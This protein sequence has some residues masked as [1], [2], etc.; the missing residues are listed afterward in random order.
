MQ[1]VP[2]KCAHQTEGVAHGESDDD[3]RG[4]RFRV[5]GFDHINGI[6]HVGPENEIHQRLRPTK[7]NKRRPET[8]PATDQRANYQPNLIRTRHGS[9]SLLIA[10]W[11]GA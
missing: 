3:E 6:D 1:F 4:R 5:E 2:E 7:Q 8:V 11:P 9:Y 10:F